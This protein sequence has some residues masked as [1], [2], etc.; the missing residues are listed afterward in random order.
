MTPVSSQ[1]VRFENGDGHEAPRVRQR[2]DGRQARVGRGAHDI[3]RQIAERSQR[4]RHGAASAIEGARGPQHAERD[5]DQEIA[6]QDA[7][8][9]IAQDRDFSCGAVA[10]QRTE[11]ECE[12]HLQAGIRQKLAAGCDPRARRGRRGDHQRKLPDVGQVRKQVDDAK[13]R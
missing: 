8:H 12:R 7:G 13:A 1:Q 2:L 3:T 9:A 5:R 11:E 4:P 6:K 10:L